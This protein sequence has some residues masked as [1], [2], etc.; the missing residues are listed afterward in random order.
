MSD[1]PLQKRIAQYFEAHQSLV[2]RRQAEILKRQG[3]L[4]A[5]KNDIFRTETVS[6]VLLS[7]SWRIGSVTGGSCWGGSPD[8]PIDGEEQPAWLEDFL[9][10]I[11][12]DITFLEF[13]RLREKCKRFEFSE[14]DYYGNCTNYAFEILTRQDFEEVLGA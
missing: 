9:E 6:D 7:P 2:A 11:A 5:Q 3:F 14:G 1:V 10:E 8:Q 4:L 13:R 12:P